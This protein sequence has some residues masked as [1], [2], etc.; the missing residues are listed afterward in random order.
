MPR[1]LKCGPVGWSRA[2]VLDSS[3]TKLVADISIPT[4]RALEAWQTDLVAY[5]RDIR[6]ILILEVASAHKKSLF[7]CKSQKWE[8]YR[9]FPADLANQWPRWKVEV[10]PLVIGVYGTV[11]NFVK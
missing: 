5:L 10:V 1:R 8:K 6:T 4:D 11:Q 9:E 3:R 7:E 2:E